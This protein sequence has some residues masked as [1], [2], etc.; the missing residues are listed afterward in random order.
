MAITHTSNPALSDKSLTKAANEFQP[1][2]ASAGAGGGAAGTAVGRRT[3][4][5][6]APEH[7]A[8]TMTMGG[9]LTACGV[10]LVLL[11]AAAYFGWTQVDQTTGIDAQGNVVN[12]TTWPTW[13]IFVGLGA[14]GLGLVTAFKPTW[15]RFTSP[16]YALGMGV[17]LGAISAVYNSS[18]DGIVLQAVMLTAGVFLF[19]LFL[20]ATRIIKVTRRLAMGIVAA[21]GAIMLVYL[22]TFVWGLFTGHRP[23]IYDAGPLGIGISVVIVAVAAFNLLLDFDFIERGT[24]AGLPKGMEWYAAFGLLVTLVWLYLEVLRLLAKLRQ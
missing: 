9:V 5:G 14:I 20:Y 2:W 11:L 18:F 16:I 19:M 17:F 12:T 10:L 3:A 22:V 21:T 24:Q 4:F 6:D 23:L 7:G 13:T 1:G 8:A 15:A